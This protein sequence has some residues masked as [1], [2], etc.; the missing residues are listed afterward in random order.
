MTT[1]KNKHLADEKPDDGDETP[2]TET[3]GGSDPCGAL[4][5]E[6]EGEQSAPKKVKAGGPVGGI[7][8]EFALPLL[9]A[10][11]KWWQS[12]KG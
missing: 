11:L 8:D 3:E 7:V 10:L 9:L 12:R 5:A 1:H 4:I 6:V 2:K